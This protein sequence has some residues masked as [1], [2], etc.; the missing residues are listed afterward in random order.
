M[1]P[2][3][4][5]G[6]TATFTIVFKVNP[7]VTGP[8]SGTAGASAQ[9]ADPFSANNSVTLSTPVGPGRGMPYRR[10]L[11]GLAADSAPGTGGGE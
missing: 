6:S 4:P 7:G 8:I 9:T 1:G 3:F 2:A 10:F 11:I 5:N